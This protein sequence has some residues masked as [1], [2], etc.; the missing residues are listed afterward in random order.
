[1]SKQTTISASIS[2]SGKGLHTGKQV[3]VTLPKENTKPEIIGGNYKKVTY[4]QT[5]KGDTIQISPISAAIYTFY[6]L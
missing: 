4:K 3:T 5:K 1:M 2:L 6:H